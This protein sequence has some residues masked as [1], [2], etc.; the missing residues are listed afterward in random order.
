MHGGVHEPHHY[1]ARIALGARLRQWRHLEQRKIS[2]VAAALGVS[3]S[4]WGHWETGERMP[5]GDMLLALEDLTGMPLHVLF[6][7]HLENCPLAAIQNGE[8]HPPSCCHCG[9]AHNGGRPPPR[10]S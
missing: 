3:T 9:D 1:T 7:P 8:P 4:T 6:C 5:L 2:D 10:T